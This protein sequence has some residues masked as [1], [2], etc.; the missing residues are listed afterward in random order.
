MRTLIPC[1]ILA[2]ICQAGIAGSTLSIPKSELDFT[3]QRSVTKSTQD[4]SPSFVALEVSTTTLTPTQLVWPTQVGETSRFQWSTLPPVTLKV[5]PLLSKSSSE[6]IRLI[7][8]VSYSLLERQALLGNLIVTQDVSLVALNAGIELKP[9]RLQY[10]RLSTFAAGI[11]RPTMMSS[12]NSALGP[13]TSNFGLSAQLEAGIQGNLPL[14]LK[15]IG[16]SQSYLTLGGGALLPIPRSLGG[17]S[18]LNGAGIL[19]G[20]R[21]EVL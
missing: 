3:P 15:A 10:K 21:M 14:E 2:L 6:E 20:I 17:I 9:L 1:A 5:L 11:L 4:L 16:I 7:T 13:S 8:G 18:G 12:A 19:A